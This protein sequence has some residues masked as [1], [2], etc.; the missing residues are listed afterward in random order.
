MVLGMT[1]NYLHDIER[2]EYRDALRYTTTT[3]CYQHTYKSAR[4]RLVCVDCGDELSV[5]DTL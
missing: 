3:P 4:S 1:D 5:E 2:E